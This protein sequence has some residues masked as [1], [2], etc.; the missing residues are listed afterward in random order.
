MYGRIW[1][2]DIPCKLVW[3]HLEGIPKTPCCPVFQ[4][5]SVFPASSRNR[6]PPAEEYILFKGIVRRETSGTD[7]D[8]IQI[9]MISHTIADVS[10]VNLN[11]PGCLNFKKQ[12]K[13]GGICFEVDA[14][15]NHSILSE[16][17]CKL[18]RRRLL[19][20]FFWP[21]DSFCFLCW[22][23]FLDICYLLHFIKLTI[24]KM[25]LFIS[26]MA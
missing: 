8:V 5:L 26:K 23:S 4:L 16:V 24:K 1:Y 14:T 15:K 12:V 21:A 20:L 3:K 6:S 22:I 2:N 7:T 18:T 11:G 25:V 10:Q 13:K 19:F 17:Q 9:V